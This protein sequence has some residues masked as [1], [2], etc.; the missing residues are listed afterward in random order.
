VP[1]EKLKAARNRLA[2]FRL[3]EMMAMPSTPRE[4]GDVAPFSTRSMMRVVHHFADG[5]IRR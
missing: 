5:G 1:F 3:T 2:A 4:S